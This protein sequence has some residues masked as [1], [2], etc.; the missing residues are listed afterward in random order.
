MRIVLVRLSAL[1]D[2]VHTWPL[3]QALR[4]A[5][6][7]HHVTWVVEEPFLPLIDG[8][9]AVDATIAVATRR[10]RRHPFDARTRAQIRILATARTTGSPRP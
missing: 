4:D 8:H 1:G 7:T 5:D 6:S 3:A 9:P 10:W 2:I